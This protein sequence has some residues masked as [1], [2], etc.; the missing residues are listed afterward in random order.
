MSNAV[1]HLSLSEE[2]KVI[3]RQFVE[4]GK[5]YGRKEL[6]TVI[7]ERA[8]R[9]EEM[10]EGVIAGVIKML[11]SSNEIVAVSRGRYR[12]GIPMNNQGIQ[13]KVM[14]VFNK[15]KSDLDKMCM[16]NALNLEEKD[17]AFI[18]KLSEI[19]NSL[20]FFIWELEDMEEKTVKECEQRNPTESTK[21]PVKKETSMLKEIKEKKK[22]GN[23]KKEETAV[24]KTK[25]TEIKADTNIAKEKMTENKEK[26]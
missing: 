26:K 21:E 24:T 15:F 12:K 23:E 5:E 20:E 14:A 11:T 6:V 19:C 9:K 18:R 16:V 7:K 3:V 17:I 8:E 4:A 22:E 25:S 10:T 13:D 2:G 1:K